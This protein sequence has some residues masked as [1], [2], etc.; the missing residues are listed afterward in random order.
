MAEP[1]VMERTI[2]EDLDKLIPMVLEMDTYSEEVADLTEEMTDLTEKLNTLKAKQSLALAKRQGI[3][4]AFWREARFQDKA[5][6]RK[7]REANF[8][9]HV[10][11]LK[12]DDGKTI[13]L[14]IIAHNPSKD[15]LSHIREIFGSGRF[16]DDQDGGQ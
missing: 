5:W 16:E 14:K 8:C 1:E 15:A 7:A 13:G 6:F 3:N 12:H 2:L 4:I 9:L 11:K 10:K